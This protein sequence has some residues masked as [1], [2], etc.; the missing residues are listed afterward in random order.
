MKHHPADA[1]AVLLAAAG[2]ELIRW[3]R[4]LRKTP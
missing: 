2:I 1:L 3:A 4:L